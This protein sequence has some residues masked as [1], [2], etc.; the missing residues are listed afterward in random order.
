MTPGIVRARRVEAHFARQ[1]RKI[2][3]AVADL[4]RAYPDLDLVASAELGTTLDRYSEAI[5][6]WARASAAAMQ[7][8]VDRRDLDAW[9]ELSATM[10]RGLMRE[11]AT[12]PTGEAMRGLLA[13]QV[14]LIKS[15]PLH[16][17]ERVHHWTLQGIADGTRASEVSRE[18]QRTSEVSV[19]RANLIAR[20]EVARTASVLT[21]ARAEHV[22]SREYVW[23]TSG[24]T[25]VRPSHKKMNA[26]VV[27][28]SAPPTLDKLT[29]HAGALPNCRCYPE[30]IIPDV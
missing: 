1:L 12:A 9:R 25:D 28:W 18:I 13:E 8:N 14:T 11:I 2:A 23:R 16:A 24:D 22:G 26:V 21:Q 10:R 5:G 20:T 3:Y 17:A 4:V 6:P 27:L 7:A 29:G 19:A 15:I 30:P